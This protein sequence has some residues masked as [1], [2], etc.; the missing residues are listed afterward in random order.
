MPTERQ[1]L[2]AKIRAEAERYVNQHRRP[3]QGGHEVPSNE[4]R[5]AA[6][7][8]KFGLSALD[9]SYFMTYSRYCAHPWSKG[10]CDKCP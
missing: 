8:K 1:I 3:C 5:N 7:G 9:V 6:V 2:G 4:E 10:A